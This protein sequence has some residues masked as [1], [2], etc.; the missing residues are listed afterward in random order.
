MHAETGSVNGVRSAPASQPRNFPKVAPVRFAEAKSLLSSRYAH[1]PPARIIDD[2]KTNFT[3]DINK[4]RHIVEYAI[5]LTVYSEHKKGLVVAHALEAMKNLE[6]IIPNDSALHDAYLSA[7]LDH[8][9]HPDYRI[10]SPSRIGLKRMF[11]SCKRENRSRIISRLY[12]CFR[13]ASL[14][15]DPKKLETI[16]SNLLYILEQSQKVE[17]D[18]DTQ[19]LLMDFAYDLLHGSNHALRCKMAKDLGRL[20][21][22][23]PD[24]IDE[25]LLWATDL[26][27][28]HNLDPNTE[29]GRSNQEVKDWSARGLRAL[30]VRVG[31]LQTSSTNEQTQARSAIVMDLTRNL[32]TSKGEYVQVNVIRALAECAVYMTEH[33]E[34]IDE[35]LNI[36]SESNDPEL[37]AAALE[38]M[39]RIRVSRTETAGNGFSKSSRPPEGISQE[40]Q[41]FIRHLGLTLD[42]P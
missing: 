22:L 35:I 3:T 26:V 24:Y 36:F 6:P 4:M 42:T 28:A 13:N 10:G 15:K 16:G 11:F 5:R 27:N 34:E 23:A 20:A 12:E 37:R 39:G 9:D 40:G 38:A 33:K 19:R 32:I 1:L 31:K 7:F 18:K 2:I 25:I 8:A 21:R 30:A 29:E 17:T 41:D 14:A